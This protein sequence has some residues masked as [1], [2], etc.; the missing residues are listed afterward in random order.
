SCRETTSTRNLLD[1]ISEYRFGTVLFGF[2]SMSVC[3]GCAHGSHTRSGTERGTL[4]RMTDALV[5]GL[6]IATLTLAVAGGL[7]VAI[8]AATIRFLR[9]I[10][11]LASEESPT[12][13]IVVAARDEERAIGGALLALRELAPSGE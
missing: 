1:V 5:L 2:P 12:V 13:S 4:Q 10:E 7:E 9:D 8:G 11:P 3:K 6:A